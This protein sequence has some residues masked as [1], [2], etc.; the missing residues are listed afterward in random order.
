MPL[1][2]PLLLVLRMPKYGHH[3]VCVCACVRA[4]VC[5]RAHVCAHLMKYLR[6][7]DANFAPQIQYDCSSVNFMLI[8]SVFQVTSVIMVHCYIR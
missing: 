8:V 1:L 4:C 3:A 6:W 5:V 7:F 2:L